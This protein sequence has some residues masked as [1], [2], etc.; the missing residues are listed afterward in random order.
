VVFFFSMPVAIPVTAASMSYAS[1]VF[2]GFAAI[3]ILCDIIRGR[4]DFNGPPVPQDVTL[5]DI[6]VQALQEAAIGEKSPEDGQSNSM[7][8]KGGKEDGKSVLQ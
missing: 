2:A 8:G 1:V 3:S 5:G 6:R 7:C 4:K